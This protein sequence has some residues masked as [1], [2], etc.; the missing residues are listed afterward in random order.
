MYISEISSLSI[1]VDGL[2]N[3]YCIHAYC[4]HCRHPFVI[5]KVEPRF[6][7]TELR[8]T[9]NVQEL[10]MMISRCFDKIIAVSTKIPKIDAILFPELKH[11]GYLFSISRFEDEVMRYVLSNAYLMT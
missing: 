1:Y 10:H 5:L 8:I 4:I 7:T 2:A 11:M 3:K 6:G 9:P